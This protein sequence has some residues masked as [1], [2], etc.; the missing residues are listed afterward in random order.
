VVVVQQ[1]FGTRRG[2]VLDTSACVLFT[3]RDGKIADARGHFY[4]L[5]AVDSWWA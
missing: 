2:K 4:D 5:H 1:N 3:I